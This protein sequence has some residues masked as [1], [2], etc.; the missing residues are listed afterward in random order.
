MSERQRPYR[1]RPDRP[2]RRGPPFVCLPAEDPGAGP[3]PPPAAPARFEPVHSDMRR[4]LRYV[5]FRANA[6]T[7][8][9]VQIASLAAATAQ[10]L[11]ERGVLRKEDLD[12]R[13]AALSTEFAR[14]FRTRN[15]GVAFNVLEADKYTTEKKAA[16]DCENRIHLC[17]AACCKLRFALSRQDVEEGIIRWD[18]GNPYMI[19]REPDGYCTHLDSATHACSVYD[20]RPLTCRAYDCRKDKRIWLDFDARVVNPLVAQADWPEC[21]PAGSGPPPHESET[22]G[23]LE[24]RT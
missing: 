1:V 17:R 11:E 4:A 18:F 10:L 2:D 6:N 14:Q 15:M 20:A 3:P 16:I 5:H 12:E 7:G 8:E 21:L 23:P 13:K 24:V 9:L 22:V 19:A